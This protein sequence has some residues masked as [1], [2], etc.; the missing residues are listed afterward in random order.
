[1][2]KSQGPGGQSFYKEQNIST[3]GIL[4]SKQIAGFERSP[5]VNFSKTLMPC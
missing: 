4:L 2:V 1:M 5:A 3:H